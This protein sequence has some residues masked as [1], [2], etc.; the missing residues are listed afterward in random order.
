[1]KKID[2]HIH[3]KAVKNS[4]TSNKRNIPS[5]EEFLKILDD[6]N[7]GLGAI[8]NH[9]TFDFEQYQQILNEIKK[10]NYDILILPGVEL[11]VLLKDVKEY[12]QLNLV[13]NPNYINELVNFLEEK[14]V[15]PMNP[16]PIQEIFLKFGKDKKALFFIDYKKNGRRKFNDEEIKKY[17]L[18]NKNNFQNEVIRDVNDRL[19]CNNLIKL[20]NENALIGSDVQDWSKYTSEDSK[21]LFQ[22]NFP[23]KN[24][25][26][27]YRIFSEG[28]SLDFFKEIDLVH[29]FKNLFIKNESND[30]DQMLEKLKNIPIIKNNVNIIFGPKSTG[31]TFLLQAMYDSLEVDETKKE[32]HIIDEKSLSTE[33]VATRLGKSKNNYFEDLINDI[34]KK[35][36]FVKNYNEKDLKT[37][38]NL[39]EFYDYL[40]YKKNSIYKLSNAN[41][42]VEIQDTNTSNKYSEI[43]KN[44]NLAFSEIEK[45]NFDKYKSK[46]KIIKNLI[47]FFKKEKFECNYKFYK[48]KLLKSTI[49]T[50]AKLLKRDKN[51]PTKINT[52]G[53]LEVYK[54]RKILFKNIDSIN[55][56]L[57]NKEKVKRKV[58]AID[59]PIEN[60]NEMRHWVLFKNFNRGWIKGEK[61]KVKE[62][63]DKIIELCDSFSEI[64]SY[65]INLSISKCSEVFKNANKQEISKMYS[66][67][68]ELILENN[69]EREPS[70]GELSYLEIISILKN[71]DKDYY[72][73]DEPEMHLNNKF[74]SDH[75]LKEIKELISLGKTVIMTTHN[76]VLG[77][78]TFPVN[79]I[80]RESKYV[81][82][83]NLKIHD[84]WFGNLSENV[85]HNC[86]N[87]N[88]TLNTNKKILEYF[89]G[90]K[91]L[92]DERNKVYK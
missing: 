33:H 20:K 26:M 47:T 51:V 13:V 32:I 36:E 29:T 38:N 10:N 89:E 64:L 90:R 30:K 77:I 28:Y 86:F 21:D 40:F 4:D 39:K 63:K 22:Y 7:V 1:M 81:E 62:R 79:F 14:K 19:H 49:D 74:I 45:F 12:K 66:I 58:D 88:E 8:T 67:S 80:L 3:T 41:L 44:L 59:V 55:C 53:L 60:S 48:N 83:G 50:F 75:I 52:F 65:K 11:D 24:Y 2:L 76:S 69:P 37:K 91:D 61:T 16:I 71:K 85:L 84:T 15:S 18:D 56:E 46:L 72:F 23:L 31:K 82:I 5:I 25:E 92:Y 27:L 78:N 87:K 9:N 54:K 42:E 70:P 17:F 43:I 57:K 6:S 68:D 34:N 73:I 35:I